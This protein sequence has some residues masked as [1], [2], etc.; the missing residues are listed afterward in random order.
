M[1]R[2]PRSPSIIFLMGPTGAGKTE[3]ALTLAGQLDVEVISVDSAMVYREMDIGTAK[4]NSEIR[5]RVPH[6]LVDIC[7]PEERYS[8]ARFCKDARIA[9]DAALKRGRIPLLVGGTGLYFRALEKGLAN[10][11]A[12]DPDMRIHL[13]ERVNTEGLAAL[14]TELQGVDPGSAAKI[15]PNDPQRILRALEVFHLSGKAMSTLIADSD[16]NG[17]QA[18]VIKVV[19]APGDRPRLHEALARRFQQMLDE[20]FVE[21]V[22]RLLQRPGLVAGMPS[23]RLVGYRQIGEYLGGM[24]DYDNAVTSAITATRRLAKR[25]LTWL[26]AERDCKWFDCQDGKA[27][28]SVLKFLCADTTLTT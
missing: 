8:A 26:R 7:D 25:Q 6:Q 21:E 4:P 24:D 3:L 10:L 20:G 16:S 14:H 19:L 12:A 17:L 13:A 27:R 23:M 15:H 5:R 11:P 22:R 2:E 1:K 18:S 9:I 28:A